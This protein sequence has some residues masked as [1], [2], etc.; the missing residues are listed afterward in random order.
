MDEVLDDADLVLEAGDL[1][2]QG[3]F[4][5]YTPDGLFDQCLGIINQVDQNLSVYVE[6]VLEFQRGK[7]E[8]PGPILIAGGVAEDGRLESGGKYRPVPPRGGG[9]VGGHDLVLGPDVGGEVK[10]FAFVAQGGSDSVFLDPVGAA[11]PG[12]LG[13]LTVDGGGLWQVRLFH[14][15]ALDCSV[16]GNT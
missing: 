11:G 6:E 4:L 3:W 15:G 12:V 14:H 13:G 7:S 8:D 16:R 9:G 2:D 1:L 10:E 5:L